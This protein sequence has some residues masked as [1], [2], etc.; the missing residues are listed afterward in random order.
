MQHIPTSIAHPNFTRRAFLALAAGLAARLPIVAQTSDGKIPIT[1]VANPNLDPFDTLMTSFVKENKVPG[2]SLAV[3]RQGKLVYARGFGYA[4]VD[5]KEPV[6]PDALFRIAS[7]SKPITGVAVM[8]LAEKQ[9]LKLDDKVM[10]LM[11]VTPL[12]AP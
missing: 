2:A 9:K 1:G 7:V 10:D 11:K 6:Q 4:D 8:Q 5:Q 12:A 3:T